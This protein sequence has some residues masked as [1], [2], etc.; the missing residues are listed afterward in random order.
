MTGWPG[1]IFSYQGHAP[2]IDPGAYIPPGARITGQVTI[3]RNASVWF[4]CVLRGDLASIEVG[5][6]SNIQDLTTVHIQG[7]SER[8]GGRAPPARADWNEK[9]VQKLL[10]K[11][12]KGE[13]FA[14]T[15][16]YPSKDVQIVLF[17]VSNS[18]TYWID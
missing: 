6:G 13:G 7:S 10:D 17:T 8:G 11:V 2:R 9:D 12:A 3:A 16:A 4:N 14:D 1:Q 18:G 15:D 5:E